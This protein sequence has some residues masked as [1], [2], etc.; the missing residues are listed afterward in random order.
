MKES[1]N[2]ENKEGKESK[3][4]KEKKIV[5]QDIKDDSLPSNKEILDKLNE[6]I[7]INKEIAISSKY[8][9]RRLRNRKILLAVKWSLLA[10]VIILGFISY[11]TIFEYIRE[12]VNDIEVV[13]NNFLDWV[14]NK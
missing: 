13:M 7:E 12:N 1:E 3:E 9:A 2:K 10:A 5:Y 11:N 14:S 4:N 6:L 8:S